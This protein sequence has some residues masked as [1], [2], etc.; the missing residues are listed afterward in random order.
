MLVNYMAGGSGVTG[1][2]LIFFSL[3]L[4]LVLLQRIVDIYVGALSKKFLVATYGGTTTWR[5]GLAEA[6]I[7]MVRDSP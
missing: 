1:G 6:H 5:F 4:Q 2:F 7:L 3:Y